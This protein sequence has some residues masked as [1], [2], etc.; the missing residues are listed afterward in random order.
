MVNGYTAGKGSVALLPS[1]AY[2]KA[3]ILTYRVFS[4]IFLTQTVQADVPSLQDIKIASTSKKISAL[5]SH[6]AI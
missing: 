2:L 4:T 6:Q 3:S 1:L 5:A